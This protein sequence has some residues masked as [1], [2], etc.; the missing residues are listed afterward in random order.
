MGNLE[1]KLKQLGFIDEFEQAEKAIKI[2]ERWHGELVVPAINELRYAGFHIK[3]YLKTNDEDQL[4]KA[5]NHCRRARY[6]AY[7]VGIAYSI[8]EFRK[9][10]DDYR[11]VIIT[12]IIADFPE[13]EHEF[14]ET[15]DFI[16]NTQKETREEV[17]LECERRYQNL[18]NIIRRLDAARNELNKLIKKELRNLIWFWASIA[19]VLLTALGIIWAIYSKCSN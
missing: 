14:L 4:V 19:G 8:E 16:N 2:V 18:C 7:E 17:Y 10:K 13:I 5:I 9:F 3:E 15:L 11:N 12:E 6:D 1:E